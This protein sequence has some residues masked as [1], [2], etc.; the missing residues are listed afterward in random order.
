MTEPATP[1]DELWIDSPAALEAQFTE[2]PDRIGLDTE[3]IRERTFW[4]QLALVQI[5]IAD[6]VL[7]VDPTVE[8]MPETLRM[9]LGD[10]RTLKIMHSASEDMVA[11]GHTCNMLPSPVFDTQITASLAGITP[12][13][14]YQRLVQELLGVA[15]D[16][17]ETRSD[18]LRRPLTPSQRHYAAEDVRHLFALHDALSAQLDSLGRTAWAA[19]DCALFVEQAGDGI[20]PWPHLAVRAAQNLDAP[21]QA[22]LLR[23]L[24]WR[25][26]RARERDMPRNWVLPQDLALDIARANPA[27]TDALGTVLARNPKAPRSLAPLILDA[28]ATPQPD[29]PD[30]PLAQDDRQ[31]DRA[32]LQRLQAKVAAR[33]AELGLGDGVLA[34]RR[35]LLA[36]LES[37]AWPERISAWRRAELETLVSTPEP[38]DAPA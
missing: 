22:R 28:M 26:S 36:W 27:S 18:W 6:R 15:L 7:L 23:L 31:Q 34:P 4:P 12:G 38:A 33:S 9:V 21:A 25:D 10:T 20:D 8:G 24:R 30:M 16:K 32:R 35:L 2:T 3:F 37:G 11:F 13:I 29:E 5:A 1:A 19:Q 17:G 14:G